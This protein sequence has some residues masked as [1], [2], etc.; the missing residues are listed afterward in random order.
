MTYAVYL[1]A[2]TLTIMP[3]ILKPSVDVELVVSLH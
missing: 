1:L 3:S 2:F